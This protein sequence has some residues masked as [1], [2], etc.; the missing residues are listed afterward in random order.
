MENLLTRLVTIQLDWAIVNLRHGLDLDVVAV[1]V[2][3]AL[4]GNVASNVF[5]HELCK[6]FPVLGLK[7]ALRTKHSNII[8]RHLRLI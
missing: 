2:L 8:M 5:R 6:V 7:I 3:H 4:A 1:R